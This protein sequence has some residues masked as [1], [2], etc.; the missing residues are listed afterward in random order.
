MSEAM[1]A[2]IGN[3]SIGLGE[4]YIG[5]AAKDGEAVQVPDLASEPSSPMRDL[6]VRAG[7]RG[8]LVMPLLRPSRIV[9]ALVVRRKD[10]EVKRIGPICA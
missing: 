1:I 5:V 7:Y 8:L 9:G 10:A 3:Q 4:S 2:E 6:V